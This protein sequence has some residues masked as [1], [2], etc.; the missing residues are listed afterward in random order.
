MVCL[1]IWKRG[2]CF[3]NQSAFSEDYRKLFFKGNSYFFGEIFALTVSSFLQV[4]LIQISSWY[5]EYVLSFSDLN[6]KKNQTPQMLIETK[7]Y[8][9]MVQKTVMMTQQWNTEVKPPPIWEKHHHLN[10]SQWNKIVNTTLTQ[11]IKNIKVTPA[12]EML[13]V[14]E[15]V[16]YKKWSHRTF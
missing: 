16:P 8:A 5:V 3:P 1:Y 6:K 15:I 2:I 4:S 14:Y 12:C 7:A 9:L 13:D 10:P 11:N